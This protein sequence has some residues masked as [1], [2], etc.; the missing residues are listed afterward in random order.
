MKLASLV[1]QSMQRVSGEVVAPCSVPV[2]RS[3]LRVSAL[4]RAGARQPKGR[5]RWWFQAV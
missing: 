3:S 4:A 2:G 1:N 5:W